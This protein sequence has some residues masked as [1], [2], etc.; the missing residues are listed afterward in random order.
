MAFDAQPPPAEDD[1]EE[2]AEIPEDLA[3][4][5][6]GEQQKRIIFR[7][8]YMMFFGTALV[9]VARAKKIRLQKYARLCTDMGT[10]CPEFH[11]VPH[12]R[13]F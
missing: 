6:K 3:M 5:D 2:E 10:L 12:A 7:A 11:G 8:C 4:L 13:L 9:L 1:E